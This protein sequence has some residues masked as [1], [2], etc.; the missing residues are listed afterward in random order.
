M[1]TERKDCMDYLAFYQDCMYGQWRTGEEVSYRLEEEQLTI[2]VTT[3]E[4]QVSF[5]VKL[6]LPKK[7]TKEKFGGKSP[8]LV[9]MHPIQPK[10]YLVSEGYAVVVLDT[11]QVASDDC[12][13]NG[14]FYELYP[15]TDDPKTQTG[16]LMAW[17]WAASKVLDAMEAGLATEKNLDQ[18]GT[19]V[20][21]V[22]RWGKATAVCGAFEKRLPW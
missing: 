16:V 17:G 9:C 3:R 6:Y 15:Y 5:R 14:C 18:Q 10:D 13:H 11:L 20:T 8:V 21:G 19:I 22:S 7:A 4:K 1:P 2:F 12:K